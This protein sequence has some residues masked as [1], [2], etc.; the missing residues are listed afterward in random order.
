M[1][2]FAASS[3]LTPCTYR[4]FIAVHLLRLSMDFLSKK[5]KR[6]TFSCIIL[7]ALGKCTAILLHT[8]NMKSTCQ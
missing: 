2:R 5:N 4:Q 6:L 7:G 1:Y 8:P 3:T